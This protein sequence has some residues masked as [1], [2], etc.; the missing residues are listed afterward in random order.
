[1]DVKEY[2]GLLANV[3]NQRIQEL[4]AKK[5]AL[6]AE[7]EKLGEMSITKG[8][9]VDEYLARQE[10]LDSERTSITEAMEDFVAFSDW[11]LKTIDTQAAKAMKAG[12]K[13][14]VNP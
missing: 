10:T 7:Q 13:K 14:E 2:R 1:M 9:D 6:R 8:E 3:I 12:Q 11:L 5:H 4:Q